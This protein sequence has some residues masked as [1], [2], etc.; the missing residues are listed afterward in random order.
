MNATIEVWRP[1]IAVPARLRSAVAAFSDIRRLRD[2]GGVDFVRL[3]GQELLWCDGISRWHTDRMQEHRYSALF[4]LRNDTGS[5]VES[6]GVYP[7]PQPPGTM[8]FLDIYRPHRLWHPRG[9]RAPVGAW[10]AAFADMADVPA[11]RRECERTI[12]AALTT[13]P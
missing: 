7:V 1:R 5:M 3:D 2:D 9:M 6:R 11:S 13:A 4:I 8:V 12:R 10:L